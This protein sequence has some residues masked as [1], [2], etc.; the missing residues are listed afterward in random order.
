V[1]PEPSQTS[2]LSQCYKTLRHHVLIVGKIKICSSDSATYT[3][4][5]GESSN[6]QK[7]PEPGKR[8]E[9]FGVVTE[10][11]PSI[12][13]QLKD[14]NWFRER[15]VRAYEQKHTPY[16]HKIFSGFMPLFLRHAK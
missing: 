13:F 14:W 2:P 4:S 12:Y 3:S 11:T 7:F 15:I 8:T 5:L 16:A 6:I 10:R 9:D 1:E